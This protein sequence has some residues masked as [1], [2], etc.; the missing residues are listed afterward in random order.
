MRKTSKTKL[1][2]CLSIILVPHSTNEVKTIKITSVHNKL[3]ILSTIALT[4]TICIGLY[5]ASIIH[6]NNNLKIALD[7]AN[8]KNKKQATLLAQNAEQIST[9]LE[10]EEQYAKN[11]SDF[12]DKYKQMTENFVDESMESFTASRG[13]GGRSFIENAS[14]LRN[15]L[16]HL[17]EI[18]TSEDSG[19]VNKLSDSEKKLQT[20]IESFPTLWPASGRISS[21]FGYR[22]DPFNS[23]EKRHQ[24]IDIAASEGDNI[25]ASANGKVILSAY[26]GNYGN[27]IIINHN[28]G[29]TTLY[30]HASSLIAKEG[31]TV[32]KGDVIAKVGSTGRSTGPHLHFE[33]RI[34]GTPEDPIK[35]LDKK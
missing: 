8:K 35:Y 13:S 4:F 16:D 6:T 24:G 29:I 26:N 5:F 19:V 30:A 21:P 31:Q 11:I 20:Y 18:N 9:L 34:N 33:V 17:Q 10:R 7:E 3:Y 22:S 28:N 23:S 2:K 12:S 32:K 14:E 15:I 1:D 25:K 27:C